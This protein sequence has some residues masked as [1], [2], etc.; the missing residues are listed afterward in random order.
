VTLRT[1]ADTTSDWSWN[2]VPAVVGAVIALGGAGLL[3]SWWFRSGDRAA[4][5]E[6]EANRGRNPFNE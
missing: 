4:R 6:I 2:F 5:A 3:M 1:V